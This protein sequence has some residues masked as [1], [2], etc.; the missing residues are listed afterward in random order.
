MFELKL[1]CWRPISN[2][3][4]PMFQASQL[5]T[6]FDGDPTARDG[7]AR[8]QELARTKHCHDVGRQLLWH[9]EHRVCSALPLRKI[10]H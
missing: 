6:A 4:L 3:I 5:R 8:Q 10:A 9:A 1:V 2:L 7:R